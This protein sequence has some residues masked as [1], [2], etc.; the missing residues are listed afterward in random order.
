[1]NAQSKQSR[2]GRVWPAPWI[3]A[4]AL[5]LA[6][7]GLPARAAVFAPQ[8]ADTV[9]AK[10]GRSGT[11]SERA[12]VHVDDMTFDA[13]PTTEAAING[14]QWLNGIVYYQW[15]L[16]VTEDEK[17]KWLEAAHAW[18]LVANVQFR[19][20]SYYDSNYRGNDIMVADSGPEGENN[21]P[22]G[23]HTGTRWM[24]ISTEGFDQPAVM[25][26][27]IGHTLG[28]I[29]EH[30]RFDRDGYVEILT[31][32]IE[33]G[34]GGNFSLVN[35]GLVYGAYDFESIMHYAACSFSKDCAQLHYV[36]DCTHPTIQPRT[37][38]EAMA[39]LMGYAAGPSVLD[40]YGMSQTYGGTLC[41]TPNLLSPRDGYGCLAPDGLLTWEAV[42]GATRYRVQISMEES[43]YAIALEALQTGTSY[44][45][46]GLGNDRS[47][48]WRV[49]A[50]TPICGMGER[51]APRKFTIEPKVAP[52]PPTA[53]YP[54]NGSTTVPTSG[55]LNSSVVPGAN[56]YTFVIRCASGD[57]VAG[58]NSPG[59]YFYYQLE[60]A[61]YTWTASAS[62]RC[63]TSAPSAPARFTVGA[64]STCTVPLLSDPPNGANCASPT[65]LVLR[66]NAIP[67]ARGYI[68]GFDKSKGIGHEFTTTTN[69]FRPSRLNPGEVYYWHVR[70]D[71]PCS[72]FSEA[73]TLRIMPEPPR[74]VDKLLAPLNLA[75]DQ[76]LRGQLEWQPLDGAVAYR[77]RLGTVCDSGVVI[78]SA[79]P[80]AGYQGLAQNTTY[81][82]SVQ[83]QDSCGQWGGYGR[84]W[85]FH[86]YWHTGL[87]RVYVADGLTLHR[88]QIGAVIPV[89]L[90]N[91]RDLANLHV[92]VR[93]NAQL[94]SITGWNLEG[95][96]FQGAA[97]TEVRLRTD[98]IDANIHFAPTDRC[99]PAVAAGNGVAL[100]VIVQVR[101]DAALGSFPVD[102][103]SGDARAC[104]DPPISFTLFDGVAQ[105]VDPVVGVGPEIDAPPGRVTLLPIAPNP[106]R[107]EAAIRFGVPTTQPVTIEIFNVAGRR[108]ATVFEGVRPGGWAMVRWDGRSADGVRLSAGV[109]FVRVRGAVEEDRQ[110]LILIR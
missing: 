63:R 103:N 14:N 60:P 110:R 99:P 2:R 101:N 19:Q 86:T 50:E 87:N 31:S 102:I 15:A 30:Q 35:S 58:G 1:M 96:R 36:C 34:K 45:L 91:L 69:E 46:P 98:E 9:Q 64:G 18:T 8:S 21:S 27:E 100:N 22:V 82:W 59:A 6:T 51:S 66:W 26:H 79:A 71:C 39:P 107:S 12:I 41:R 11:E 109:Y 40:A 76:S 37:G 74:S 17:R 53:L 106:M 16:G 49:Q 13:G 62:N 52:V 105:I 73:R 44:Q 88:G 65:D 67:G 93:V 70:L 5:A 29:H 33:D 104:D 92:R 57:I 90:E 89:R 108:V 42:P 55:Y 32:N 75:T 80:S 4:V 7:A 43:F 28:L 23:E 85:S 38:Y 47:Y 95:T 77:V 68:V 10:I 56:S 61:T 81:Y 83:A 3:L 84:C 94:L 54:V 72:Q 78:P 20:V 24:M 97:S 48:Y 25:E